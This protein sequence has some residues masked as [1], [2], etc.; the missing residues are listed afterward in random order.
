MKRLRVMHVV[1]GGDIGGAERVVADLATRPETTAADHQV[2]LFTPNRALAEFFT[3]AGVRVHDRGPV[4]ENPFAYVYRS[5]GPDAAWLAERVRGEAIDVVHTHTFGSHVLGTRAARRA[6]V[7]QVRTEHHVMHYFDPS[8]AAFTRWAASRT[9]RFV[10]VSD[11]VRRVLLETAPR[12]A[13]R[14]TV[15]RNGVDAAYFAPPG[16]ARPDFRRAE[17]AGDDASSRP[18]RLGVV[19]RLTAWKRVHL[20]VEAAAVTGAELVV[21]G[22]GEDRDKLEALAQERRARVSFVG[23]QADPRPHVAA[24][25]AIL[26]TADREPLGL[27]VLEALALERP[28]I[29][30]ATGGI[31]EVVQDQRTGFLVNEPTVEALGAAIARAQSD[32]AG[33]AVMGERGRRFVVEQCSIERMAEGYGAAYAE[34]LAF[35]GRAP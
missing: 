12:L 29:A 35:P 3:R 25:D 2:A 31:P 24:C 21:I 34:T 18:L 7:R 10:A 15:V 16:D 33:L 8:C 32:R 19:C 4:R 13:N 14:M 20:A 26:S 30:F 6:M 27:S 1:V 9:D 28:V 5:F 11:Y 22:D 17:L 23:Y